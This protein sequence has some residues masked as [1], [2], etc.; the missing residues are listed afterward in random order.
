MHEMH[1][2][3]PDLPIVFVEHLLKSK[4]EEKIK[5]QE[6]QDIIIKRF[7]GFGGLRFLGYV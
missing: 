3:L 6:I 1:L 7:L 5:K 2:I 4:K